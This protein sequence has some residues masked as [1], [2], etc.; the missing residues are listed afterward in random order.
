M[1]TLQRKVSRCLEITTS[2]TSK[3]A[4]LFVAVVN[5]WSP[6]RS[7]GPGLS[8]TSQDSLA[9]TTFNEWQGIVRS[10]TV[11][12]EVFPNTLHY[13][14]VQTPSLINDYYCHC[15]LNSAG[16][17]R[18]CAA[19]SSRKNVTGRSRLHSSKLNSSSDFPI[20]KRPSE[21]SS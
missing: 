2:V 18:L 11:L 8:K 12:Y 6:V 7:T 15:T 3:S 21:A 4:V 5:G 16:S 1:I 13:Y 10:I 17:V 20:L 19:G 14:S 9:L